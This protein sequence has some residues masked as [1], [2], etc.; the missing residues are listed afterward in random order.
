MNDLI[1]IDANIFLAYDNIN[2]ANHKKGLKILEEVEA[3]RYGDYFTSDYI[4]NEIVG[5]TFRKKG[6]ERAVLLGE[7]VLKS[8]LVIN[9]D[10]YLVRE[11]WNI[12]STTKLNLNLV[13]CT[14]LVMMKITGADFIA[15]LDKEFTRI[16]GLEVIS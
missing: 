3:G 8:V 16:N 11:A 15:T 4:F 1:F 9:V 7:Q 6:K 10:D 12:F 2:D 14:N 13:D 5:V